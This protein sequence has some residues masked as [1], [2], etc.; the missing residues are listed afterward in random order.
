MKKIFIVLSLFMALYALPKISKAD[1]YQN[2]EQFN[3]VSGKTLD[4]YSSS[5]LKSYYKK[6]DKRK[7]YGWR[8][9][10]VGSR[11]KATFI[12]ETMFSYYNDGHTAIE[13]NY[14]SEETKTEKISVS[15]TGSIGANFSGNKNGFKGG[16]DGELKVVSNNESSTIKKETYSIKLNIDPGTQVN[17]YTYGEGYLTNGVAAKYFAWFRTNRGGFEYF[18]ISTIYYRLEKIKI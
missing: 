14:K 15:T 10:K 12:A 11:L 17:L 5:D 7:F 8:T 2:F 4:N 16:L 3:L 6:V 13:Y 18:E 9:E 1:H